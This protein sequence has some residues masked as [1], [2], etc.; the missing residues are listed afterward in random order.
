MAKEIRW[1]T[2]AIIDR[3]NIYKYWLQRNQ[4]EV[5]PEKLELKL[6]HS[7]IHGTFLNLDIT[8]VNGKFL[9][10]LFDKRDAFPFSIVRMSHF[11]GNIPKSIF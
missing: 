6:E 5:Y 11:H 3:T 2:R 4:S 9:N 8:I 7:G 1:T 10:K